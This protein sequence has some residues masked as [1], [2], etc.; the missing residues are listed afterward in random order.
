HGYAEYFAIGL[1]PAGH[2]EI[3]APS[4]PNPPPGSDRL[5]WTELPGGDEV[6]HASAKDW[7]KQGKPNRVPVLGIG[8]RLVGVT[9]TSKNAASRLQLIAWKAS[10]GISTQLAPAG[11]RT[12]PVRGSQAASAAWYD[13]A[14]NSSERAELAKALQASLGSDQYLIIPR[15]P[16]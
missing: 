6:Y 13:A 11:E 14:V 9:A 8:D 7:E 1:P 12:M 15:I 3:Q 2:R 16:G 10:A 4:S 5:G